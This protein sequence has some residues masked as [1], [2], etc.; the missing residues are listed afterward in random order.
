MMEIIAIALPWIVLLFSI[1]IHELG[2]G[3]MAYYLGDPTAKYEGRLTLNP[4][5]HLDPIGSILVPLILVITTGTWFGWAKP[6]RWNPHYI[7]DKKWGRLKVAIAGPLSNITLALLFGLIVRFIPA[8][9]DYFLTLRALLGYVVLI[10]LMLATFNLMPVPPLDGSDVLGAF[11]P[12]LTRWKDN[13]PFSIQFIFLYAVV[14]FLSP[15]VSFFVS[16]LFSAITGTSINAIF[17][18]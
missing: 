12:A 18:I 9:G 3:Y 6:V 13:L 17:A 4:L 10:N 7:S 15:V 2:H 14:G 5:A 8:L 1:I 11:I 16:L